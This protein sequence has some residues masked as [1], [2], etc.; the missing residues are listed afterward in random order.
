MSGEYRGCLVILAESQPLALYVHCG[1]HC[2]NLVSQSVAEACPLVRN[3]LNTL[4]ELVKLF[5][6]SINARNKFKQIVEMN[7]NNNAS[8]KQSRLLCPIRWLIRV[9]TINSL[10]S[11]YEFILQCLKQI[12]VTSGPLTTRASGLL[13]ALSKA[14]FVLS[15]HMALAVFQPLETLNKTLQST[16]KT[17]AGMFSAVNEV[18]ENLSST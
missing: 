11:Q 16:K 14:S 13:N 9:R 1:A 8:R 7:N 2:I 18:V 10:V 4:N 12:S 17:V 15:L 5:S 3:A 6:Q